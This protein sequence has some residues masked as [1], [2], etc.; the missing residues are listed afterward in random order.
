V[1]HG[2]PPITATVLHFIHKYFIWVIVSSYIVATFFPRI[3]LLIR[4]TE[5][6][7]ID[8]AHMKISVSL[9]PAMLA[10]LLFNAGL[11]IRATELTGLKRKPYVLIAGA[12]GNLLVPL[13]F[14]VCV[15]IIMKL[16]HDPEE[17]QQIL[18]GLSLVASMPIAGAS[19][20]WSQNANGNLTLSLGLILLTT[21]SSP[22]LTP[23]VLH[24]GGFITAGHYS[25][26]LHELAKSGTDLFL[27]IWVILP[28]L[29]GMLTHRILGEKRSALISPYLK[30]ANFIVL[31]LLNY[32]N[33]S[34]TLPG[35]ISQPD[36][37]FVIVMLII[38][39]LLCFVM[40]GA[41]YMLAHVF[42]V[43]RAEMAS[44]MFGLGMNNNG[45]GLVMASIEFSD[46][47]SVMLPIIFY[48]LV[49][50]FTAALVDKI[51]SQGVRGGKD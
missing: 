29:L 6:G 11:G 8:I 7:N 34:L 19:T 3:G 17:V 30:L 5:L 33:A 28:S 43:G 9:P 47:P 18:T 14:I 45:A 50:H 51:L 48:N 37:D 15:N 36:L 22:I 23:I 41:G 21:L 38:V 44:L 27:S 42:R 20:A 13:A 12:T 10:F 40:F 46:H 16:W 31:A 25:E 1:N 2:L 35:L 49:Q 32:S 24:A 39:I 4:S 26:D